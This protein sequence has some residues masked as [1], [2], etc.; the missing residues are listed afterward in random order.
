MW[1]LKSDGKISKKKPSNR[2][3]LGYPFVQISGD[4]AK[5]S[6]PINRMSISKKITTHPDIAHPGDFPLAN[7]RNPFCSLLVK[8]AKGVCS[9]GVLKQ[10]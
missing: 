5:I 7:E 6:E 3:F 10:P 2:P 1:S 4:V 9:K 8:V